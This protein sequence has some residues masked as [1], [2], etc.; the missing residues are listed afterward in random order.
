[1][2]H[3]LHKIIC[4]ETRKVKATQAIPRKSAA[5][6]SGCFRHAP[7][8]MWWSKWVKLSLSWP[9]ARCCTDRGTPIWQLQQHHYCMSIIATYIFYRELLC[10]WYCC[11]YP[12]HS[13]PV[14]TCLL[15]KIRSWQNCTRS[16]FWNDNFFL[17][18]TH[19]ALNQ[20]ISK[21]GIAFV[22]NSILYLPMKDSFR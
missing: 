21:F 2:T 16:G 12:R 18:P 14:T 11:E 8:A 13:A 6:N 4:V 3:T 19:M 5:S 15:Q 22:I 9:R 10:V 17:A 1:M 7:S 20:F